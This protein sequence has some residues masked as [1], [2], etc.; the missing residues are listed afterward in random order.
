MVHFDTGMTCP[1]HLEMTQIGARQINREAEGEVGNSV[2]FYRPI[3]RLST[4]SPV[5]LSV[6]LCLPRSPVSAIW[7]D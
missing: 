7:V 4:L 1:K 5:N 2:G 6:I 3:E